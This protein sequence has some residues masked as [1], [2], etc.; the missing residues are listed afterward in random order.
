MVQLKPEKKLSDAN[1]YTLKYGPKNNQRDKWINYLQQ[2]KDN[3]HT[4][5][6]VFWEKDLDNPGFDKNSLFIVLDGNKPIGSI[7][8]Q[9]ISRSAS[10][11]YAYISYFYLRKEFTK[12]SLPLRMILWI[13]KDLEKRGV[14]EIFTTFPEE[15]K[16]KFMAFTRQGFTTIDVEVFLQ[17]N[18]EQIPEREKDSP[19]S[20]TPAR[21]EE[22]LKEAIILHNNCFADT[23]YEPITFEEMSYL[24]KKTDNFDLNQF[25][26]AHTARG[27]MGVIHYY[28]FDNEGWIHGLGVKP[29]YRNRGVSKELLSECLT[30]IKRDRAKRAIISTVESSLPQLIY[31]KNN[32]IPFRRNIVMQLGIK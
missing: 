27:D 32:F 22:E 5:V 23:N 20:I 4:D 14:K 21:N 12:T 19:I 3:V 24:V 26:I 15:N 8:G 29:R 10:K 7:S 31:E 30:R 6:P 9:V 28:L 1:I 25:L 17:H 16:W 18:L 2:L 13:T 11:A